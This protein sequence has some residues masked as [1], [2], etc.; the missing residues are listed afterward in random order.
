MAGKSSNVVA[1]M[2]EEKALI[3][4]RVQ[5]LVYQIPEA[6]GDGTS[7]VTDILAAE[8]ASDLIGDADSNADDL[9]DMLGHSIRIDSVQRWKSDFEED[10]Q[11]TDQ[12]VIVHG[13]DLDANKDVVFTVGAA[14]PIVKLAKLHAFGAFPAVAIFQYSS[15]KTSNGYYPLNMS[16]T[17]VTERETVNA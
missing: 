9:D 6:G 12:Y 3:L 15:K 11:I 10:G 7:F 17:Q 13:Y 16:V 4:S 14:T 5:D 8:K 1:T 2:T